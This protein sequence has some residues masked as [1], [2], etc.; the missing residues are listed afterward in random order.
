MRMVEAWGAKF[1]AKSNDFQHQHIQM[2]YEYAKKAQTSR[3]VRPLAI[4]L[5]RGCWTL[6]TWCEL[7]NDFR[8][9]CIHRIVLINLTPRFFPVIDGEELKDFINKMHRKHG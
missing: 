3:E 7:R 4:H 1:H 6:L 5:G 2:D 8:S 9:F